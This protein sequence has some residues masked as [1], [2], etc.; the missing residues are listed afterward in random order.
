MRWDSDW[1]IWTDVIPYHSSFSRY[2]N[3]SE[4]ALF[5]L[6]GTTYKQQHPKD[7]FLCYWQILKQNKSLSLNQYNY[8]QVQCGH[9]TVSMN[10]GRFT[11]TTILVSSL[12][13]FPTSNL[14]HQLTMVGF[15]NWNAVSITCIIEFYSNQLCMHF[16]DEM[17]YCLNLSASLLFYFQN[18]RNVMII[19]LLILFRYYTQ[20]SSNSNSS[21]YADWHVLYWGEQKH[22]VSHHIK[23]I[24][25][26][27]SLALQTIW[28][29]GLQIPHCTTI[30]HNL[31][32][33]LNTRISRHPA[34]C[35]V[36]QDVCSS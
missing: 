23:H 28:L 31:H 13:L 5:I 33:S 29:F 4:N 3:V 21:R 27:S 17:R 25:I 15:W 19:N 35:T 2:G 26:M 9:G 30:H 8:Q 12:T 10:L 1:I 16:V 14:L 36:C 24:F 7:T 11:S 18:V 22:P 32:I 34:H 6:G 20:W